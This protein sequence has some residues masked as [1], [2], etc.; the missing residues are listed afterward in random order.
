MC[1]SS[2]DNL[3]QRIIPRLVFAGNSASEALYE[4]ERHDKAFEKYQKDYAIGGI[5]WLVV[6][7]I[8][9]G[10]SAEYQVLAGGKLGKSKKGS[11]PSQTLIEAL[12]PPAAEEVASLNAEESRRTEKVQELEASRREASE[13]QRPA[14][15]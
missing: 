13:N 1:G 4:K 5:K 11:K 10:S 6:R 8:K 3:C 14:I 12:R 2:C 15:D 7:L 9:R